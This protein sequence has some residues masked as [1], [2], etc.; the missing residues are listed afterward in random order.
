MNLVSCVLKRG[1]I[2]PETVGPM[3]HA[4]RRTK[5]ILGRSN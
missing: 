1:W 2:P 3:H 5:A 4:I